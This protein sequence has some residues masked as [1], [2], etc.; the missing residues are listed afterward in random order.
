MQL[1]YGLTLSQM[2]TKWASILNPLLGN[3]VNN[4]SILK[5]VSLKSGSNTINTML[6]RPLQGWSVVRQR[7]AAEIYDDQDANQSP[8]LTLVLV[9]NAAVSVD[10]LVF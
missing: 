6:G 3:P 1:P 4:G 8:N 2:Q 7:G 9:S 10:L 5:N